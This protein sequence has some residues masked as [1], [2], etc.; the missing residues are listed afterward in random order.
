MAAVCKHI[1][2][3]LTAARHRG[4]LAHVDTVAA[5]RHVPADPCCCCRARAIAPRRIGLGRRIVSAA[6]IYPHRP[7]TA[8]QRCSQPLLPVSVELRVAASVRTVRDLSYRRHPPSRAYVLACPLAGWLARS[9]GSWLA[10][11]AHPADASS[12]PVL[13]TRRALPRRHAVRPTARRPGAVAATPSSAPGPLRLLVAGTSTE[14]RRECLCERLRRRCRR[15]CLE[16]TATTETAA[17]AW[18]RALLIETDSVVVCSRLRRI[19]PPL[20][21]RETDRF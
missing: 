16:T 12:S 17:A 21:A 8:V 6:A 13:S 5:S 14:W 4:V 19:P 10:A 9:R 18:A 11:A 3:K 15:C 1:R 2:V 20:Q 7:P